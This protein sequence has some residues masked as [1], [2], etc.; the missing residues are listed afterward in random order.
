MVV[1]GRGYNI[2][3]AKILSDIYRKVLLNDAL[4]VKL[5]TKFS[6]KI[7]EIGARFYISLS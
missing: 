2:E 7:I 4:N 3:F 1:R 6:I 5:I